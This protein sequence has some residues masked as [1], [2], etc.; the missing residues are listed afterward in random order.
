MISVS[1][2]DCSGIFNESLKCDFDKLLMVV[3]QII[4]Q[5]SYPV[6]RVV[7]KIHIRWVGVEKRIPR[8]LEEQAQPQTSQSQKITRKVAFADIYHCESSLDEQVWN[9]S[10]NSK[11][12]EVLQLRTYRVYQF[13]HQNRI[14]GFMDIIRFRLHHNIKE[15]DYSGNLARLH[16]VN[17]CR[18]FH[19]RK[20][21]KKGPEVLAGIPATMLGRVPTR[22]LANHGQATI[23]DF[24]HIHDRC[25]IHNKMHHRPNQGFLII[26]TRRGIQGLFEQLFPEFVKLSY[27]GRLCD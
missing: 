25:E 9:H 18:D 27:F 14:R 23:L 1:K 12:N 6:L 8:L 4:V 22:A 3:H 7:E 26:V 17:D 20:R 2:F 11:C 13:R 15:I 21:M 19:N 5:A 10:L 24:E 16:A